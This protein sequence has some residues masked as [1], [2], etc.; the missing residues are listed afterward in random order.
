MATFQV[1][2][3]LKLLK[4]ITLRGV[5]SII[6]VAT[7]AII[8]KFTNLE[9]LGIYQSNLTAVLLITCL[10]LFGLDSLIL[11]EKKT[12]ESSREHNYAPT[13][14]TLVF[15]TITIGIPST[16][17]YSAFLQHKI[18]NPIELLLATGTSFF[19]ASNLLNAAILRSTQHEF[20]ATITES[21]VWQSTLLLL[22]YVLFTDTDS[23]IN[24]ES[25]TL[26]LLYSASI[27][28][29]IS[30]LLTDFKLINRLSIKNISVLPILKKSAP[31]YSIGILSF[32]NSAMYIML[33]TAL[34]GPE[35]VG[36]F[37]IYLITLN[38][39]RLIFFT[40]SNTIASSVASAHHRN[41]KQAC[42]W[43]FSNSRK[44]LIILTSLGCT[45]WIVSMPFIYSY[46]GI[47]SDLNT[48]GFFAIIIALWIRSSAG[49]A[50]IYLKMT[51]N[52][53]FERNALSASSL[54]GFISCLI[55]IPAFGANGAALAYLLDTAVYTAYI[56]FI[57]KKKDLT[58]SSI[59]SDTREQ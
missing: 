36:L 50:G 20:K 13:F 2:Q 4:L 57:F 38:S 16:F 45:L 10:I 51:Q 40:I 43:T 3:M 18:L 56:L 26:V 48:W 58:H 47:G 23:N 21:L 44:Q 30:F 54:S 7:T 37:T 28:T 41:D 17:A 33:L 14:I 5:G 49:P 35:E 9:F 25:I 27:C 52:S 31:F 59:I 6:P 53:H 39:L 12:L 22:F 34:S 11:A 42:V 32:L 46:L 55:F 24:S 15:T 1:N 29:V 19:L 8:S